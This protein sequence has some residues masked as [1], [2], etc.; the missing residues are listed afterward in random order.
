MRRLNRPG[1][2]RTIHTGTE[3]NLSVPF[4]FAASLDH[5]SVSDD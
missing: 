1:S 4:S 5:Y 3:L 2:W